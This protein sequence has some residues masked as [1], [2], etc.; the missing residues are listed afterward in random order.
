M[1]VNIKADTWGM[2]TSGLCL[3]HCMAT[4]ILFIAQACSL[5]CCAKAPVWWRLL[6]Y[7]FLLVSFVAIFYASRST[8]KKWVGI[9]LWSV[10]FFLLFAKLDEQLETAV[11][12][13]LFVYV[14]GISLIAL[15]MYNHRY[16]QCNGE[17]CCIK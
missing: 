17:D 13:E 12:P 14:S 6:D 10:W 4:P 2:I 1:K 16:C 15:H 8:A 3:I 5:T 9:A 7:L 11:L